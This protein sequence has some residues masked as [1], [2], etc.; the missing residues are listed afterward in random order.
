[1]SIDFGKIIPILLDPIVTQGRLPTSNE[2]VKAI[3]KE[4]IKRRL[5]TLAPALRRTNTMKPAKQ[6]LR[7]ISN[8]AGYMV[9]EAGRQFLKNQ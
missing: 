8:R 3:A 7:M 5:P 1:M 4:E 6:F 2:F 9:G